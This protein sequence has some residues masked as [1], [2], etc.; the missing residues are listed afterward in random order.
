MP[1]K[2]DS[3]PRLPNLWLDSKT[4]QNFHSGRDHAQ[5]QVIAMR[6]NSLGR[7]LKMQRSKKM[8]QTPTSRRKRASVQSNIIAYRSPSPTNLLQYGSP[9][10]FGSF[11]VPLTEPNSDLIKSVT[12]FIVHVV[13]PAEIRTGRGLESYVEQYQR[14]AFQLFFDEAGMHA[15]FSHLWA[16]M[17]RLKSQERDI[18]LQ[19][20][21]D[22]E[23]K[24]IQAL[25]PI[26][27][28][29]QSQTD[30]LKKIL[31]IV[32]V[33]CGIALV[34]ENREA[35]MCHLSAMARLVG[36]I[37]GLSEL[38]EMVKDQL[39][40]LTVRVGL[41]TRTR[42][43]FDPNDWDSRRLAV[44]YNDPESNANAVVES[45]LKTPWNIIF[46]DIRELELIDRFAAT[47]NDW[48]WCYLRRNAIKARVGNFWCDFTEPTKAVEPVPDASFSP[49]TVHHSSVDMC[50]C[51]A[52][53]SY[54][55]LTSESTTLAQQ[56]VSSVEM[57]H[58][59]LIRCFRA[60]HIDLARVDGTIPGAND[61][62]WVLGVGAVVETHMLWGRQQ[63]VP[64]IVLDP[65]EIESARFVMQ[66]GL[67]ALKL[68]FR[69]YE[70]VVS[71]FQH[72][73]VYNE[74]MQGSILRRS[75]Q[76]AMVHGEL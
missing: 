49:T 47:D 27:A 67:L 64:W 29:M 71:F 8:M 73:Y 16:V 22:H 60:L 62:L 65:A 41:A 59:M 44:L 55:V 68:G 7:Q 75:L 19:R 36:L 57:F 28:N 50:L 37:G 39:V 17:A 51:M 32:M 35:V 1:D 5:A 61:L 38:H 53:Q 6:A 33:H 24:A 14:S 34:T 2:Q 42:A 63:S 30:K 40:Y 21:Q 10:P 20:S 15:K 58:M 26:I 74:G 66:F 76:S 46:Q 72:E 70:D 4:P 48:R 12:T 54:V 31:H 56:M 3:N 69:R 9:D 23:R 13:F 18:C 43:V 45:A 11:P 25:R 52:V